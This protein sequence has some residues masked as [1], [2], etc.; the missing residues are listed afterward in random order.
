[1]RNLVSAEFSPREAPGQRTPGQM[2]VLK[3]GRILSPQP[4][5]SGGQ[6]GLGTEG[7]RRIEGAWNL[8]VIGQGR[9]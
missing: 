4:R 8:E 2:S 1:M 5:Q 3:I 9:V 7:S 6:Q